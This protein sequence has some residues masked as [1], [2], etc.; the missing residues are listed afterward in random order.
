MS[1]ADVRILVFVLVA[2][3]VGWFGVWLDERV[4]NRYSYVALLIITAGIIAGTVVCVV[5][6]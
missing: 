2:V 1:V 6:V 4:D 5:T 3:I